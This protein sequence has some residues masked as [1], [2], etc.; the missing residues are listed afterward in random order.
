MRLS[1]RPTM[2]SDPGFARF[3]GPMTWPPSE[4]KSWLISQYTDDGRHVHAQYIKAPRHV[5]DLSRLDAMQPRGT[6]L[7]GIL[8]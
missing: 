3:C 1:N 4:Q 2:C 8:P 6:D 7:M 5:P